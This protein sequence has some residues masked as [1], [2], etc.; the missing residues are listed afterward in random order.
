[1][2]GIDK[3]YVNKA[4]YFRAY[5]FWNHSQEKQMCDM[6]SIISLYNTP[7]DIKGMDEST[8]IALWN[9]STIQDIWLCKYCKLEF[10]RKRLAVQYDIDLLDKLADAVDFEFSEITIYQV[11]KDKEIVLDFT[12]ERNGEPLLMDSEDTILIYGDT[13]WATMVDKIISYDFSESNHFLVNYYGALLEIKEGKCYNGETG[14]EMLLPYWHSDQFSIPKF[15]QS[16]DVNDSK[17]YE[18]THIFFSESRGCTVLAE[19]DITSTDIAKAIKHGRFFVAKEV[20]PFL[21]DSS[22]STDNN[23]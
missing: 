13:T 2:A 3:T 1:M 15:V 6:G 9:T 10:I 7:E 14:E 20:Q 22:I 8:E 18:H 19:Y 12:F 5:D 17:H 4:E 21:Y 11:L 16:L 23:E